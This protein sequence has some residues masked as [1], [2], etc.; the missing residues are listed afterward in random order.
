MSFLRITS[1]KP[2]ISK[3][4]ESENLFCIFDDSRN[5]TF[6]FV[7]EGGRKLDDKEKD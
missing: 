3:L 5:F 6:L 4:H 7:R 1:N 2:C